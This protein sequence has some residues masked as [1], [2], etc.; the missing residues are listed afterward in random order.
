MADDAVDPDLTRTRRERAP[1]RIDMT[2]FEAT[3]AGTSAPGPCAQWA[4][5]WPDGRVMVVDNEDEALIMALAT[6]ICRVVRRYVTPWVQQPPA[7]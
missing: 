3:Y 4:V 7:A 5:L 2:D 1:G 6:P